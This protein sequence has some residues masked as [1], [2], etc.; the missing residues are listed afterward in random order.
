MALNNQNID[1]LF[2][3]IRFYDQQYNKI[4]DSCYS[5]VNRALNE[6]CKN[7]LTG[8][9]T[10]LPVGAYAIKNNYQV[11]EPL[12]FFCV[13]K[14]DRAVVEKER[15]QKMPKRKKNAIKDIYNNILAN[16]NQQLT[17]LDVSQIITREFKKYLSDTDKVYCK[18]NVVFVKFLLNDE[19]NTIISVIIHV[20]YDFDGSGLL[21]LSRLGHK[22][23]ENTEL[24]LNNIEQKNTQTN[25]NYLL[26]C[27]LVKMLEL[28]LIIANKSSVYLSTKTLFVENV[29]YNV[30]NKFYNTTMF[31]EMFRDVVNYLKQC[32]VDDIKLAD[33][34]KMF[35]PNGYYANQNFKSFIKKISYIYTNGDKLIEDAINQ[36][37]MQTKQTPENTDKISNNDLTSDDNNIKKINKDIE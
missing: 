1:F 30:P 14:A 8:Q 26:L 35:L 11:C 3:T 15:Q 32:D 36:S 21:E 22:T 7:Y 16:G 9:V 13:L 4:A 33:G 12:E 17:A 25:G 19:D 10:V 6:I 34:S 20:V 23:T 31:C 28:E 2:D 37:A 5:D 29:L 27:K 18:N 24:L